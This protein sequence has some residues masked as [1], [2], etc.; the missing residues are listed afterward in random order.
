MRAPRNLLRTHWFLILLRLCKCTRVNDSE[1]CPS[2]AWEP[3]SWSLKTASSTGREWSGETWELSEMYSQGRLLGAPGLTTIGVRTLLGAP[4]IATR[5]RTLLA[6]LLQTRH[7]ISLLCR[8]VTSSHG[9]DAGTL[10]REWEAGTCGSQPPGTRV[11]ARRMKEHV[12]FF[13]WLVMKEG[14]PWSIEK[15]PFLAWP[16]CTLCRQFQRVQLYR[17]GE[18]GS[19]FL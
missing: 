1:R 19:G 16:R 12:I 2:C 13:L 18:G 6:V 5:S 8:L 3:R 9:P 15:H 14:S 4:G 7:E 11:Y 17:S 10:F